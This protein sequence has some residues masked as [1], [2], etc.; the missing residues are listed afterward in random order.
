VLQPSRVLYI[1][2]SK[3]LKWLLRPWGLIEGKRQSKGSR[4]RRSPSHRS[5]QLQLTSDVTSAM[6]PRA[7]P[8]VS[9]PP[10]FRPDWETL[11]RL[12]STTSK[13]LDLDACP[14]PTSLRRFCGATDKPKSTWFWGTN[15]ETVAVIL[16]LK[17][18]NQSCRFWGPNRETLHHLDFEAQPRNPRS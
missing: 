2:P 10:V 7:P 12:A 18:P 15:Q 4:V 6:V 14:T 11:A 3:S 5:V 1:A 8:I 17:S 16:R 9:P 13:L